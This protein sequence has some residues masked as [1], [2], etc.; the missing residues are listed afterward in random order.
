ML[1]AMPE[2]GGTEIQFAD[3]KFV[4]DDIY[5]GPIGEATNGHPERF[6]LKDAMARMNEFFGKDLLRRAQSRA[7]SDHLR[8]HGLR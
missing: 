3:G 4:V 8:I 1:R 7:T 5:V 2:T 6:P